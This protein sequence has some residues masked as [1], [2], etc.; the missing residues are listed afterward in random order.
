[1]TLR[2]RS[3]PVNLLHIFKTS[4]SK[5]TSGWLLLVNAFSGSLPKLNVAFDTRNV[6]LLKVLIAPFSFTK[7]ITEGM[8]YE[9]FFFLDF[10]FFVKS[11]R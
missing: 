5:K 9:L 11:H 6:P 4:F 3:S 8:I 1:M 2:H 10:W 7:T